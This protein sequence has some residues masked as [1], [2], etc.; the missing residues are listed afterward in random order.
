[1]WSWVQC[2]RG[3][4]V[5]GVLDGGDAGWWEVLGGGGAGWWG[6]WVVRGTGWW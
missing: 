6:C 4:S 5:V 1:M 3:C 2:G